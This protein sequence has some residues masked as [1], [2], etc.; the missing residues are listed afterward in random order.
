MTAP[1]LSHGLEEQAGL[2]SW[3][4]GVWHDLGYENPPAPGCKPVP[5]L[6]ERSSAAIEGARK[7][8][9]VIGEMCGQL[10]RLRE[11]LTDELRQDGEAR[12]QAPAQPCGKCRTA[13]V[14]RP[15]EARPDGV[16][17]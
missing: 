13:A 5:P 12:R 16:T 14:A 7:A 10:G 11:Q 1:D 8:I 15:G 4:V 9:E 2:I 6:G 17:R 3:Y